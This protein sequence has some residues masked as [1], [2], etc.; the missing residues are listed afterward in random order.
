MKIVILT[1]FLGVKFQYETGK[2]LIFGGLKPI[3]YT[4]TRN[5]NFW[6][7]RALIQNMRRIIALF[8]KSE[9]Y[10]YSDW[11]VVSIFINFIAAICAGRSILCIFDISVL[12]FYDGGLCIFMPHITFDDSRTFGECFGFQATLW[13]FYRN[14]Q[15][16]K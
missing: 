2:K 14:H 8:C 11:S 15:L 3:A 1:L 7:V 4:W 13:T 6:L 5:I 16:E 10:Y 9:Y 12:E